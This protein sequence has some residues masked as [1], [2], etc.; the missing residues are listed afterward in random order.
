VGRAVRPPRDPLDRRP[1]RLSRPTL[2]ASGSGSLVGVACSI[3]PRGSAGAPVVRHSRARGSRRPP[4]DAPRSQCGAATRAREHS[5]HSSAR[6]ANSGGECPRAYP[7]GRQ[8]RDRGRGSKVGWG[9]DTHEERSVAGR[10]R[11]GPRM[12]EGPRSPRCGRGRRTRRT[13]RAVAEASACGRPRGCSVRPP[14][15][16]RTQVAA[17]GCAESCPYH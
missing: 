2:A 5:P 1:A 8:A 17:P 14:R 9:A 11:R 4:C 16:V 6:K 13:G 10:A 15:C 3:R 7:S 12:A